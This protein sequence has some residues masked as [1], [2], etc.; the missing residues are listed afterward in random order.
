MVF[1]FRH[2]SFFFSRLGR[3]TVYDGGIFALFLVGRPFCSRPWIIGAVSSCPAQN[4]ASSL[5]QDPGALYL[6]HSRPFVP[7]Q[8]MA[9]DD[10][11]GHRNCR[12]SLLAFFMFDRGSLYHR[13]RHSNHDS[14][15]RFSKIK[16][17]YP[18]HRY[19]CCGVD[20]HNRR[21]DAFYKTFSSLQ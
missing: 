4:L 1:L 2:L 11:R 17:A 9:N 21:G 16:H 10:R 14:R 15:I 13:G 6:R 8:R 20:R 19:F 12:P 18:G 5:W 3:R 7:H